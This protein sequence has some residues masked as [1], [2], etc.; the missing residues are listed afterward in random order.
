[1]SDVQL[2]TFNPSQSGRKKIININHI[3]DDVNDYYYY[4]NYDDDENRF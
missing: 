4:C 2:R 3:G 1:M